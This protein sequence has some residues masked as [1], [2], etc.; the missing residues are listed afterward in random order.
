MLSLLKNLSATLG[1]IIVLILLALYARG[2]SAT[3]DVEPEVA[4]ALEK[5]ATHALISDLAT[6]GVF[7]I[8]L[9]GS[10]TMQQSMKAMKR[11][12]ARQKLKLVAEGVP[13]RKR[14]KLAI[15]NFCDAE[16]QHRLFAFNPALIPYMPCRITLYEDQQGIVWVSAVNLDLFL[17]TTRSHDPEARAHLAALKDTLVAVINAGANGKPLD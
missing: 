9:Q 17:T 7:K 1:V 2:W 13:S 4:A 12:A 11:Q 5:F 8:P 6:A 15:L 10:V 3:Q 16:T 14:P